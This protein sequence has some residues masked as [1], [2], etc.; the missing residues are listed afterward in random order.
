MSTGIPEGMVRESIELTR[1]LAEPTG[2]KFLDIMESEVLTRVAR[3]LSD[4][5]SDEEALRERQVVIALTKM[6]EN[7][8]LEPMRLA[9]GWMATKQRGGMR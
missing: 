2:Q 1:L 6:V 9:Q 4:N 5:T 8:L 7:Q 3:I